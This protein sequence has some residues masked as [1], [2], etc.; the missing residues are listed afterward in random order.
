MLLQE[1]RF[2]EEA[3]YGTPDCVSS[4][5][6]EVNPLKLETKVADGRVQG[7]LGACIEGVSPNLHIRMIQI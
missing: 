2:Y 6:R 5:N 3:Q 7:P 4:Q 1:T